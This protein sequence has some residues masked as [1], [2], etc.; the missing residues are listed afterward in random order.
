MLDGSWIDALDILRGLD[1][2]EVCNGLTYAHGR[3]FGDT[4]NYISDVPEEKIWEYMLKQCEQNPL[5][6][7]KFGAE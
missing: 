6:D 2:L 7:F 5:R 1:S 3:E 4:R